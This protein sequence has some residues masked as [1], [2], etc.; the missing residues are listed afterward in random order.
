M[1]TGS[2]PS[3]AYDA[4]IFYLAS[5][6]AIPVEPLNVTWD[7]VRGS[8]VKMGRDSLTMLRNIRSLTS[9]HYENPVVELVTNVDVAAVAEAARHARVQGLV[10]ARGDENALLVLPRDGAP[11]GFGVAAVLDG[12]LRTAT[13]EELRGRT[14]E[15]V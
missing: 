12:K 6:L 13:I 1:R 7:D 11:A 3:F 5:Q 10:V 14:F 4:E 8:S 2:L 15:A 9:T